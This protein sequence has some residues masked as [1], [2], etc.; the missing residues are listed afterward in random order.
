M[1]TLARIL[2]VED[3]PADAK[4]VLDA[5]ADLRLDQQTLR[6]PDGIQ[7]L[8]YLNTRGKFTDRP[9]GHP[10]VV[11]LDVK[12]PGL[13]GLEVLEQLRS[14][15]SL[16]LIPV[17]MLTASRQEQDV[18]RAYGLGANGYL[19]KTID[20]LSCMASLRACGQ[21]FAMANEPP[22]GCLAPPKMAWSPE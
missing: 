13:S 15:P 4:L 9:S 8:D 19:V 7:A 12:M 11:L 16:R 14:E 6:L 2:L 10:A 21:Y 5:L 22:P 3:D 17:V 1:S 20:F 18:R